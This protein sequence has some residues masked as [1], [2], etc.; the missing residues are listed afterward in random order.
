MST[1]EIKGELVPMFIANGEHKFYNGIILLGLKKLIAIEKGDYK[2]S[3]PN[4]EYLDYHDKFII[5]YRQEGEDMYLNMAKM[6]RKAGNKL[7][8]IMLKK[9][10]TT[11]DFKFLNV[12]K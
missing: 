9:E 4:I 6:F 10:M 2:G 12:I 11:T 3:P 1:K 7:Y 8:R 5:L